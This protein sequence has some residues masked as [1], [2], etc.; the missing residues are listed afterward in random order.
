MGAVLVCIVF[1][2][3]SVVG[4]NKRLANG[5]GYIGCACGLLLRVLGVDMDA[6][7]DQVGRDRCYRIPMRAGS[8][9]LNLANAVA[10]VLYEAL[11]QLRFPDLA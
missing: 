6:V 7:L 1:A 5:G 10:V 4:G 11:R 2:T 8:R 3:P 9:S